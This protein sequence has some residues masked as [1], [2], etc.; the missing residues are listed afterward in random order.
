MI[1]P[2][3]FNGI[4]DDIESYGLV[5]LDMGYDE[6]EG[7]IVVETE[8]KRKDEDN[9]RYVLQTWEG[10]NYIKDFYIEADDSGFEYFVTIYAY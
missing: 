1:G 3:V 2:R 10:N 6:R 5:A 4:I 7:R 9:I 8:G